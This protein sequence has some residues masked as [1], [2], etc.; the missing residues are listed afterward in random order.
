LSRPSK[1]AAV[2]VCLPMLSRKVV[3]PLLLVEAVPVCLPELARKVVTPELLVVAVP[4]WR[5]GASAH[6]SSKRAVQ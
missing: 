3:T 4:V 1:L 6:H 5:P 2:L